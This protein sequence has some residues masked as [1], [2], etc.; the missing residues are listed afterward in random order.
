MRRRGS[1]GFASC[2]NC[3]ESLIGTRHTH[4]CADCIR[5]A[6]AAAIVSA[7]TTVAAAE[8]V[9]RVLRLL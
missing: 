5:C 6:A 3:N 7:L 4:L 9:A 1:T 2:L 8:I